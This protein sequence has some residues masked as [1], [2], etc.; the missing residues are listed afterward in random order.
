MLPISPP[1]QVLTSCICSCRPYKSWS[2]PGAAPLNASRLQTDTAPIGAD[3]A[4]ISSSLFEH[5]HLELHVPPFISFMCRPPSDAFISS[6]CLCSDRSMGRRCVAASWSEA[7]SHMYVGGVG[8]AYV[9]PP[10]RAQI[11]PHMDKKVH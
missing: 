9:A 11:D 2:V 1:I 6:R 4:R 5:R 3:R 7:P 8:G 10:V